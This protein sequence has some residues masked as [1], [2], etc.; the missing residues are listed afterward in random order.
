MNGFAG[1]IGNGTLG[2]FAIGNP[3]M[4]ALSAPMAFFPL[5]CYG[6]SLNG[7]GKQTAKF[8]YRPGTLHLH[9]N[10]FLQVNMTVKQI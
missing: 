8:Q 9:D 5:I 7:P 3:G 10:I 2:A 1:K 6:I 4:T